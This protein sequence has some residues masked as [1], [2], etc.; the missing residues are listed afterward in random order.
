MCKAL[1]WGVEYAVAGESR[2]CLVYTWCDGP[3]TKTRDLQLKASQR[4]I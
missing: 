4:E 2:Q 1:P 3:M